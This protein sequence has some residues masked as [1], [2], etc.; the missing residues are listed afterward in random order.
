MYESVTEKIIV[1]PGETLLCEKDKECLDMMN[2]LRETM[3]ENDMVLSILQTSTTLT[4]DVYR[5]VKD[6]YREAYRKH[7][8]CKDRCSQMVMSRY[9]P[10]SGI[11]IWNYDQLQ[12]EIYVTIDTNRTNQMM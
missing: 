2:E 6:D 7:R 1:K 5:V 8:D 3:F 10:I 4:A 9:T 12:N 11:L